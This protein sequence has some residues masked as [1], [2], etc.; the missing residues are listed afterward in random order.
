MGFNY[1]K[2]AEP[3]RGDSLLFTTKFPGIP[4]TQLIDLGK[5]RDWVNPGVSQWLVSKILFQI[6]L[7][8]RVNYNQSYQSL[9]TTR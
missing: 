5:I 1:L 9:L 8:A 2:T 4:D 7:D 6:D 3:L